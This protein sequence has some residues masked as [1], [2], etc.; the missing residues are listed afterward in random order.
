MI[1]KYRIKRIA[2]KFFIKFKVFINPPKLI[3]KYNFDYAINYWQ[4]IPKA[5]GSNPWNSK[6]L[7]LISDEE[8]LIQFESEQKIARQKKEREM[9]FVLA[10]NSISRIENAMVMDYGSGIGFY[11]F[12]V[13]DKLKDAKVTFVDISEVNLRI[14]KRIA[15]LKGY[16]KRVK[17]QAVMDQMAENLHFK[18]NFDLICS[19][20]VLHHTPYAKEIVKNLTGFLR[21]GGIFEV[22]LY[23]DHY[24]KRLSVKKGHRLSKTE[25]GELTDPTCDGLKNSFLRLIMIKKQ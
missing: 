17:T 22:M 8:L 21:T 19:M 9:G 13:L 5:K 23:N 7:E 15:S 20:G 4:N 6:L 16:T 24:K 14:I 1:N 11:G 10:I 2:I 25:F 3:E 12:E 18:E